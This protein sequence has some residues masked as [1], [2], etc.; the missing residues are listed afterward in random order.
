MLPKKPENK[1]TVSLDDFIGGAKA[2]TAPAPPAEKPL[3]RRKAADHEDWERQTF[4]IRKSHH[5]KLKDFAYTERITLK[6][7]LDKALDA[8]LK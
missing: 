7:A 5:Q 4:I 8:F 2:E 6:E 3:G 1:K